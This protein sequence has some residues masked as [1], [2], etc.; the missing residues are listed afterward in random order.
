[1]CCQDPAATSTSQS[2][3][4]AQDLPAVIDM[5]QNDVPLPSES[6]AY[7]F[8]H[9]FSPSSLGSL[10]EAGRHAT[11]SSFS[12]LA[13]TLSQRLR[14]VM[15]ARAQSR[16]M[17]NFLQAFWCPTR[18]HHVPQSASAADAG[19]G[20]RDDSVRGTTPAQ[21][22]N[23]VVCSSVAATGDDA[24]AHAGCLS[25]SASGEPPFAGGPPALGKCIIGAAGAAKA[26]HSSTP[27]QQVQ[28]QENLGLGADGMPTLRGGPLHAGQPDQL[29]VDVPKK[30]RIEVDQ[31]GVRSGFR[32]AGLEQRTSAPDANHSLPSQPTPSGPSWGRC[33]WMPLAIRWAKHQ[34][35]HR[36]PPSTRT[37]I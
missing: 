30:M 15:H 14:T 8:E 29:L 10:G 19:R 17:R 27:A 36:R 6:A 28:G 34:N 13:R 12:H 20:I 9:V 31:V 1:M 35:W 33:H 21:T 24:D 7:D 32:G 25:S 2:S 23:R 22:G 37:S 5:S 4:P 18:K 16:P 26:V 3:R 11:R